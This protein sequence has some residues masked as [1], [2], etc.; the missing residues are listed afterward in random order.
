MEGK[1]PRIAV[2]TNVLF[3][4]ANED[5]DALDALEIIRKKI[6]HAVLVVTSTVI[7]EMSYAAEAG[8]T[9]DKRRLAKR[10]LSRLLTWGI[11][12]GDFQPVGHGIIEKV[13]ERI[14]AA[15]L[16]PDEEVNDSFIIAEA[17]LAQCRILISSDSH[18]F[19]IDRE[20]LAAVLARCDVPPP[21]I[22]SPRKI[23]RDFFPKR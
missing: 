5:D 12:P 18:I 22:V 17:A 21:A 7:E 11:Q 20:G 1:S 15:G 10:A 19:A 2:D 23:V 4:L 6:P 16:I 13:A 14:R 3:D 9:P 8:D